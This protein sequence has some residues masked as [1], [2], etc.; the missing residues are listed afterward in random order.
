MFCLHSCVLNRMRRFYCY[1]MLR[2][3][4]TLQRY[5]SHKTM[6]IE[7]GIFTSVGA[8][9]A[10][11]YAF[12][13]RPIPACST[14]TKLANAAARVSAALLNTSTASTVFWGGWE[15]TDCLLRD[16]WECI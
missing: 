2:T 16:R 15:R 8:Y 6:T 12:W 3:K 14:R 13:F 4:N 9:L 5:S 1:D 7:E 10:M 11:V